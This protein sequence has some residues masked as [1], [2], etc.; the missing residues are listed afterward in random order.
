MNYRYYNIHGKEDDE[1]IN[2][3]GNDIEEDIFLL[4]NQ[5]IRMNWDIAIAED[6]A[7]A[8]DILRSMNEDIPMNEHI[9]MQ[10]QNQD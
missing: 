8:R 9:Y 4:S 5:F 1:E 3:L 10:S 6:I 7:I 2:G